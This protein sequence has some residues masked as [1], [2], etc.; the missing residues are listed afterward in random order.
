MSVTGGLS[1][2]AKNFSDVREIEMNYMYKKYHRYFLFLLLLTSLF[3][4]IS[5]ESETPSES[6]IK[7]NLGMV[8][9]GYLADPE[10]QELLL[11]LLK[12]EGIYY[13]LHEHR[14]K[15]RIYHKAEDTSRFYGLRRKVLYGEQLNPNIEESLLTIGEQERDQHIAIFK[16]VGVPFTIREV[17]GQY[18]AWSIK[19]SQYYG[20]KVDQIRQE[21]ELLTVQKLREQHKKIAKEFLRQYNKQ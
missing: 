4:L 5:C 8:A 3:C 19:Y 6:G 14:E 1:N 9:Y 10:K 17:A 13:E 15:Q 2:N 18:T 16:K 12:Q 21:M 7:V 20:P 11:D